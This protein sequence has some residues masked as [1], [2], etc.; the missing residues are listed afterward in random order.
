MAS[1]WEFRVS[2]CRGGKE[3]GKKKS[4]ERKTRS[5]IIS[6]ILTEENIARNHKVQSTQVVMK[7]LT[8]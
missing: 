4:R 8:R 7:A 5:Q 2:A 6:Y 3:R 1:I